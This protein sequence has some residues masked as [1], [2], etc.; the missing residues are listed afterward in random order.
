[1]D[2]A[3]LQGKAPPLCGENDVPRPEGTKRGP[4]D[5]RNPGGFQPAARRSAL[6]TL[7]HFC[8][9][10]RRCAVPRRVAEPPGMRRVAAGQPGGGCLSPVQDGVSGDHAASQLL[11]HKEQLPV[12][13]SSSHEHHQ[14]HLSVLLPTRLPPPQLLEAQS[15]SQSGFS[16]SWL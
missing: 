7:W 14:G 6:G 4:P 2:G 3:A 5:H 9:V 12:P 10:T 15:A 16:P 11:W 8:C 1:M 13:G